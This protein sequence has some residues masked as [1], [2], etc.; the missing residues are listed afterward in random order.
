MK[1]LA[2]SLFNKDLV[3]K[4]ISNVGYYFEVSVD[5]HKDGT[6]RSTEDMKVMKKL[7]EE[8]SSLDLKSL[9]CDSLMR[10]MAGMTKKYTKGWTGGGYHRSVFDNSLKQY[11]TFKDVDLIN[12]VG[13]ISISVEDWAQSYAT[14]YTYIVLTR[15]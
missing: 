11:K 15:K 8:I 12:D 10:T 5:R 7:E 1:S 9:D 4:D 13:K 6:P 2:E 14:F 3:S